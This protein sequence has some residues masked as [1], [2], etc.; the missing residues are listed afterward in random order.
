MLLL[1]QGH[2]TGGKI[3]AEAFHRIGRNTLEVSLQRF[4]RPHCQQAEECRRHAVG[5]R[6]VEARLLGVHSDEQ[7]AA[8]SRAKRHEGPEDA[9]SIGKDMVGEQGP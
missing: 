4:M 7:E 6:S 8:F 9:F 5:C 3:P 1:C 2:D